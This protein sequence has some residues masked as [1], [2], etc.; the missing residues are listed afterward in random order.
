MWAGAKCSHPSFP[1]L[2]RPRPRGYKHS[3]ARHLDTASLP[4]ITP[5]H[6]LPSD[7]PS[8]RTRHMTTLPPKVRFWR[9]A[10]TSASCQPPPPPPRFSSP[11]PPRWRAAPLTGPRPPRARGRPSHS[12]WGGRCL[13]CSP[14]PR[15]PRPTRRPRR[16][17]TEA[18]PAASGVQ[19]PRAVR[20][21]R[22][23]PPPPGWASRYARSHPSATGTPWSRWSRG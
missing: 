18:H 7:R 14:P 15:P 23:R 13:G 22:R 5:L 21:K 3:S 12:P 10:V 4:L 19:P 6:L 11:A 2:S 16:R 9:A 8:R 17:R 1:H 20:L